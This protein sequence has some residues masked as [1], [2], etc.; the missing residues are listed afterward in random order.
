MDKALYYGLYTGLGLIAYFLLMT[1]VDQAANIYLRILNF[2]II[3]AGI[4]FLF[5]HLMTRNGRGF[6]YIL[7][8]GS[9]VFMSAVSIITFIVFLVLYVRFIDPS[10]MEVLESSQ[11]WGHDLSLTDAAFGIGIEGVIS[12]VILS[13]MGMQWF[14]REVD[15]EDEI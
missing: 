13:F 1:F 15:N 14:K 7:G 2:F 9:G 10:F 5:K 6:G 3:A 8:L 11:I 12:G 4:Y